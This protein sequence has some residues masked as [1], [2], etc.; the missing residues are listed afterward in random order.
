MALSTRELAAFVQKVAKLQPQDPAVYGNSR[1][2]GGCASCVPTPFLGDFGMGLG[3]VSWASVA[4]GA[5]V[6][7][8]A[9][10]FVSKK[11][12]LLGAMRKSKKRS[13]KARRSRRNRRR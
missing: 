2:Y 12:R 7:A 4:L 6:G 13:R 3:D 8:G 1:V 5:V 9:L 10:Y 11:T